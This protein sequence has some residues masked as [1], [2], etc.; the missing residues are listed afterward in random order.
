MP[1]YKIKHTTRYRYQQ[2]VT[3]CHHIAHL[4]PREAQNHLWAYADLEISP[5]AMRTDRL[6]YFG[7]RQ[8]FF[9]IPE[10]HRELQVTSKGEVEI[11]APSRGLLFSNQPW[12]I[13]RDSLWN[14]PIIGFAGIVQYTFEST[15]VSQPPEVRQYAAES[16]PPGRPV[17][18]AMTDLMNRIHRDFKFDSAA[19]SVGTSVTEV[20]RQ[21][22]GV[23]Q[24]FAHLGL[25]C[26]RAMGFAAR[27][28][29]GYL[30]TTPP[31][32][33]PRMVGADASHAWLGVYV[34]ELGWLDFDPT[35]NMIP[36]ERH[37]TIAWGRDFA[38]VSPLR[39]V[40]LGGGRHAVQ[41]SVDV[42][43]V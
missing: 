36:A 26:L 23:C 17:V 3:I 5:T 24:D 43:A 20:L 14:T 41:V 6:D 33:K 11:I 19:T 25:S 8:T 31:P 1:T 32:G 21:R 29:S 40:I 18:D 9:S 30:L 4:L 35:N 12:E 34:P 16:F 7:N 13:A 22:R 15:H 37:I 38:D 28:V 10:P 39:G 2:P 42:T 27:Y